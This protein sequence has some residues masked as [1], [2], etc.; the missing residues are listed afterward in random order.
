MPYRCFLWFCPAVLPFVHVQLCGML[1]DIM[2]LVRIGC[3][4]FF[5]VSLSGEMYYCHFV[6]VGR[7]VCLVR[8]QLPVAPLRLSQENFH[9]SWLQCSAWNSL[10]PVWSSS[11]TRLHSKRQQNHSCW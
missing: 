2:F 10:S 9:L 1:L 3:L 5:Y 6:G 8:P 11:V 7:Q 4:G